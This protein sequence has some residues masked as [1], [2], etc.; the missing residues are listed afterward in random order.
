MTLETYAIISRDIINLLTK[1]SDIS[2]SFVIIKYLHK[3][4][5]SSKAINDD[6]VST[7]QDSAEFKHGR[8]EVMIGRKVLFRLDN[9]RVHTSVHS[10]AEIHNCGFEL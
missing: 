9:G 5:L 10:I 4:E 6:I 1:Q 3:K 8:S 2:S 7:L